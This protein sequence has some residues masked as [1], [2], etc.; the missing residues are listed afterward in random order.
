MAY[1]AGELIVATPLLLDPNFVQSVILVIDHD[2]DGALGVVLN[3]PSALPVRAVLPTW[4]QDVTAPEMVFAGGPVSP[5]S[6]L[7][8]ALSIGGGP[9]EGF[10]RLVGAYGLVD[11]DAEP[12]AVMADLAGVR[13]FSGYAGWGEGQLE[14]EIEEGSWYV[15]SAEPS[16]LLNPEPERLWRS[17]LRRQPGELAYAATYP[18]DATMN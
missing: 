10:K 17:V 11:L 12:S 13:I 8:V 1:H 14:A 4:A 15:V 3:R 9:A 18:R 7:A 5:D 2:A 6:A 16:D